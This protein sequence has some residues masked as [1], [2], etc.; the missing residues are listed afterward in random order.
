VLS[1][2]V[3]L[4]TATLRYIVSGIVAYGLVGSRIVRQSPVAL[5]NVL[6]L[7]IKL[8]RPVVYRIVSCSPVKQGP[9]RQR[10][11]PLCAATCSN[12]LN[13]FINFGWRPLLSRNVV[14]CNVLG[15]IV[16]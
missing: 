8:C 3:S 1:G 7:F 6:I 4:R 12:V 11:V 9:V 2:A 16:M 14:F 15:C 10:M 13:L 5:A